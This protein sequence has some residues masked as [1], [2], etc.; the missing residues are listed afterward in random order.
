MDYPSVADPSA[1]LRPHLQIE[2]TVSTLSLPPLFLPVSSF[3]AELTKADPE[4]P[5]VACIDPVENAVDKMS[6]L[7]WRV[8]DRVRQPADDDPD[9]VRHIHDL[10][11]LQPHATSHADF[12]R[13][14]IG[15][16]GQDDDRCQKIAGLPL[17]QKLQRLSELLTSDTEY[18]TEY[19]RFVQGMSYA[20]GRV[21]TYEEAMGKLR[22]LIDHLL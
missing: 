4:I 15:M 3:I 17:S 11:I 5:A 12:K 1:A 18:R 8:P 16:I 2:V 7:V 9:L 20:T 6:A 21:P 10:A 13:L 19:T 22:T 14:T